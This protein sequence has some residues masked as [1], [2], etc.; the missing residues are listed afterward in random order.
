MTVQGPP[1]QAQPRRDNSQAAIKDL[2]ALWH[3][4]GENAPKFVELLTREENKHD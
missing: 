4:A 1:T 3:L 2:L